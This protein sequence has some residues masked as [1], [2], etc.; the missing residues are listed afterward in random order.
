MVDLKGRSTAFNELK[1]V[2]EYW[3]EQNLTSPSKFRLDS[4]KG[5]ISANKECWILTEMKDGQIVRSLIRDAESINNKMVHIW[6]DSFELR[7]WTLEDR[8]KSIDHLR[9]GA[10]FILFRSGEV[11]IQG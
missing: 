5:P 7:T 6:N 9:A 10:L 2:L 11:L 3:H 4:Y 8:Y 1:R